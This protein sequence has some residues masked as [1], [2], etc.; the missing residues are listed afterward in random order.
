M[1]R[2]T[3]SKAR[4][5]K[6]R[7]AALAV[8]RGSGLNPALTPACAEILRLM[9]ADGEELVVDG[10]E[11]WVGT[12]RTSRSVFTKLVSECLIAQDGQD[13]IY[14]HAKEEECRRVLD[15]PNYET[16]WREAQRTGRP[17]IR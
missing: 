3:T 5:P 7:R 17:T 1:T 2:S 4:Q 6:V 10:I 16:M 9:L 13:S 15:D 12:R 14:W 11:V 8:T